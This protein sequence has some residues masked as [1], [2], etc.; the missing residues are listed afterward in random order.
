MITTVRR[1]KIRLTPLDSLT[2][3]PTVRRNDFGDISYT[4]RFIGDFVLYFVAMATG[5]GRGRILLPVIIQSPD[6]EN[7]LQ[8]AGISAIHSIQA[9]L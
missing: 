2:N 1:L 5:F 7:P 9:E 3:K 8:G 6:P 4:R